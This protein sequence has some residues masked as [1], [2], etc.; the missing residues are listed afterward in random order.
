MDIDRHQNWL[1]NFSFSCVVGVHA[2]LRR[3]G[4]PIDDTVFRCIIHTLGPA[5]NINRVFVAPEKAI[6]TEVRYLFLSMARDLL[7]KQNGER[8][9]RLAILLPWKKL[10]GHET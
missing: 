4:N 2:A 1:R 7:R 3:D 6:R 5:Q 8:S 9:P 10:F